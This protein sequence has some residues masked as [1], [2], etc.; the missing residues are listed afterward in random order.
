MSNPTDRRTTGPT[1]R[2]VFGRFG[3]VALAVMLIVAVSLSNSLFRGMRLDLTENNLYTLSDGTLRILDNIDEVI[4]VYFFYSDRATGESPYIRTY[5]GRVR[6]TLEELAE[7][8]GDKLRITLVD[9]LPFSEDEDRA[10]EFGLQAINL[11][12]SAEPVYM[13]IAATNSTDDQEIIAFLDPSK[14]TFLEYELAKLVDTLA[15]PQRPIIGVM[16]DLPMTGAFN[17]AIQRVD[18]PWVVQSQI[19]QRFDIRQVPNVALQIDV[20]IAVLVVIH[21]KS[22]SD[23]TLYAIDQFI[24]HGGRALLMVDPYAE[25]DMPTPNP[26]D[27]TAALTQSRTSSLN[28]LLG[29]WGLSVSTDEYVADDRFALTIS[30]YGNRPTRHL[31]LLGIDP[32]AIDG[33]DIVT[34][35][36]RSLNFAYA[37]SITTMDA[38]AADVT[39]LVWSSDQAALLSIDGLAFLTD[40]STLRTDFA[41]TGERYMLAVRI[42]GQVPSAF[43][44]TPPDGAD[45]TV[46]GAHISAAPDPINVI[47][48]ADTDFLTDRLWTQVQNFFG[49][50]VSTAFANNGDVVV[51]SLDNLSGSGDLISVRGRATF[52]RPF[53]RVQELRRTAESRFLETEQRLQQELQ[54]TENKLHD[55]QVS[56]QDSSA[57]ILT[58]E[59]EAELQRFQQ[60]RLRIRKELRQVQ[61]D[62]DQ[63]IEDLGTQLKIINVGLMPLL[64]TFASIIIV[65]IR[66]QHRRN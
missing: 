19:E 26:S 65:L 10:A 3:L 54:D 24:L 55:L 7:H 12:G 2:V 11:P 5:A 66:R 33:D 20:D 16:S 46:A 1:E 52:T 25:V 44:D 42:E 23:A 48:I 49:Q 38:S 9:P 62:L 34:R 4:N 53:T 8:S 31:G 28:P 57:M 40:P 39:P 30:G 50:R 63:Q 60:E 59:Q 58:T 18:E 51:N 41:P 27:P 35:G 6:E 64:I 22:L 47:L 15:N 13:G 21:P 36:L 56:R 14:E 17:P 32:A 37:G 61:R 29:T 45:A 43:G